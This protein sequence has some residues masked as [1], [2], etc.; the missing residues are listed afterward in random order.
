VE[1]VRFCIRVTFISLFTESLVIEMV[2]TSEID[3][4][5]TDMLFIT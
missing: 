1:H 5:H 4:L 3:L 2:F